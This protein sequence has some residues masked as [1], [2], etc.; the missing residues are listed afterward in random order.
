VAS[1]PGALRRP[2]EGPLA[3]AWSRRTAAATRATRAADA[4]AVIAV[5][6]P[7]PDMPGPRAASRGDRWRALTPLL[8]ADGAAAR[9][10]LSSVI[11]RRRRPGDAWLIEPAPFILPSGHIPLTEP[12]VGGRPGGNQP[13]GLP[14]APA[15]RGIPSE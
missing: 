12:T 1:V 6:L 10:R 14:M 7:T 9:R 5:A 4:P 8:P 3:P 15:Q 2:D 11:G 13:C